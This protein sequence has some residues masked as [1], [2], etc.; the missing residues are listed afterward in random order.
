MAKS[1][2]AEGDQ[3]AAARAAE[4]KRELQKLV[5]SI[6]GD[7]GDDVN[8]D[9][10]DRA[11]ET[12]RA[13]RELKLKRSVGLKACDSLCGGDASAAGAVPEEFKCP[14]S[15]ELMRDPVIIASGQVFDL[16]L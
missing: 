5:K 2:A 1:G 16:F 15:M 3:A 6:A 4:L 12:L 9:A 7:D 13:L 10:V 14:L 8:L 11:Q